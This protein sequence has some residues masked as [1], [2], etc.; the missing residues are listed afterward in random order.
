MG[1]DQ[2]G[3]QHGLDVRRNREIKRLREQQLQPPQ[4]PKQRRRGTRG[5]H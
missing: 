4:Q 3:K 5:G 2:R 1:K